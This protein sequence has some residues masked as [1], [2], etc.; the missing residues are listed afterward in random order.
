MITPMMMNG[1][2][3]IAQEVTIPPMISI[4]AIDERRSTT[5]IAAPHRGQ[6]LAASR[7]MLACD[8]TKAAK[9]D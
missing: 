2:P 7:S 9:G 4:D 1:I 3:M 6:V 5:A 8:T